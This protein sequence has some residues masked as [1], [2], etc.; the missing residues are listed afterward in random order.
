MHSSHAS[1]VTSE[2]PGNEERREANWV[3]TG[4]KCPRVHHKK[5]KKP[6]HFAFWLLLARSTSVPVARSRSSPEAPLTLTTSHQPPAAGPA[7]VTSALR[8]VLVHVGDVDSISSSI[9]G[10]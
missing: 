3:S 6:S 4:L 10:V 5:Q 2:A 8:L 9:A 7:L 1:R